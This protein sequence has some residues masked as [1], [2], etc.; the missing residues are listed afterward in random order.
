MTAPVTTRGRRKPWLQMAPWLYQRNWMWILTLT[1][2]LKQWCLMT[3]LPHAPF[4]PTNLPTE[5]ADYPITYLSQDSL[6]TLLHRTKVV[7]KAIFLLAHLPKSQSRCTNVD[8]LRIK[9][10]HGYMIKESRRLM[11]EKL[12]HNSKAVIEHLFNNHHYCDLSWCKPKQVTIEV[13]NI[14]NK[15]P[16]LIPSPVSPLLRL[17]A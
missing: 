4:C 7:A 6:P 5:K 3:T 1:F 10:Y 14:I 8:T 12:R 2:S 17:L 9:K 15:L 11:L 16:V 13:E